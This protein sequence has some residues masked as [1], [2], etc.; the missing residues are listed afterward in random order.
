MLLKEKDELV[1][2]EKQ[3]ASYMNKPFINI[4]KSL[5]LKENQRSPPITLGSYS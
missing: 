4:R 3:L 1:S 5:D 2:N